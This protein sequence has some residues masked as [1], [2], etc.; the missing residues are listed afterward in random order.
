VAAKRQQLAGTVEGAE[1]CRHHTPGN[2]KF[3]KKMVKILHFGS[4]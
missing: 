4:I 1:G 2:Y 3:M